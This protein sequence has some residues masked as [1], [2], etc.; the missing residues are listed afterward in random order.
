MK[1]QLEKIAQVCHEVNR[2]YCL[3][4]GDDSQV[5]WADAPEWQRQSAYNGVVYHFNNADSTPADSHASWYAEKEADGWVY[6]EEKDTE[7]KTHPCMVE[8]EDL[9][10]EQ[11]AKDFMFSAIVKTMK[12]QG[13]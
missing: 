2:A 4:L 3:A 10:V 1:P 13:V 9:P 12:A 11:Q 7:L 6:G 8:Y 5:A